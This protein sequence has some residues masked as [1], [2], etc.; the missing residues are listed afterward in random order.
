MR[1]APLVNGLSA[2]RDVARSAGQRMDSSLVLGRSL[3]PHHAAMSQN[4][5][6]SLD[7]SPS[8]RS[9]RDVGRILSYVGGWLGI[10]AMLVLAP[11]FLATGLMAP[12]WGV[13]LVMA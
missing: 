13:V 12:L 5:A 6:M 3:H 10:A 4:G 1:W 2:G 8:G 7:A 11:F 9:G